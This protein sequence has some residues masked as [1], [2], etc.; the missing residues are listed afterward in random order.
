[1]VGKTFAGEEAT[2]VGLGQTETRG[3]SSNCQV[4]AQ[5]LRFCCIL[6]LK[7]RCFFVT[8]DRKD[9]L[10]S[11]SSSR[12]FWKIFGG[13]FSDSWVSTK[14]SSGFRKSSSKVKAM[15][16]FS[17]FFFSASSDG[18][19]I[20]WCRGSGFE[21]FRPVGGLHG[22]QPKTEGTTWYMGNLFK[23]MQLWWVWKLPGHCWLGTSSQSGCQRE[24]APRANSLWNHQ[25]LCLSRFSLAV[26]RR[27]ESEEAVLQ[28]GSKRVG[29]NS[30]RNAL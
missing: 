25:V 22:L 20:C 29:L 1:M 7:I 5:H 26:S 12:A 23:L 18:P 17:T 9:I 27:E 28:S 2:F 16:W 13:C 21:G 8:L 4:Q 30:N 24:G 3:S 19:G 14:K 6:P 11:G 15:R 10:F